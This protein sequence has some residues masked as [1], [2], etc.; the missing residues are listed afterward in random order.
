MTNSGGVPTVGWTTKDKVAN[1]I[2]SGGIYHPTY[3][4]PYVIG[5]ENAKNDFVNRITEEMKARGAVFDPASVKQDPNTG[6]Y[7]FN[8]QVSDVYDTSGRKITYENNPKYGWIPVA[9]G[10]ITSKLRDSIIAEAD[11]AA[12]TGHTYTPK[13]LNYNDVVNYDYT[14]KPSIGNTATKITKPD[15]S[16]QVSN[17]AKTAG[18]IINPD[19]SNAAPVTPV[20]PIRQVPVT[21]LGPSGQQAISTAAAPIQTSSSTPKLTINPAAPS[22]PLKLATQTPSPVAQMNAGQPLKN[23]GTSPVK[24]T[25]VIQQPKPNALVNLGTTI[26]KTIDTGISNLKKLL[27]LK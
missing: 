17:V 8:Q 1:M 21:P 23:I 11:R 18:Q 25:P 24:N 22:T 12:E 3:T 16:Q 13:I 2:D 20:A 26:G 19:V 14:N 4:Q 9:A 7:Y 6:Q 5:D 27:G 15:L 10:P